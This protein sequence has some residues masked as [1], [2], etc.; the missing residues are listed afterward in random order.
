MIRNYFSL[1]V[2][3][4]ILTSCHKNRDGGGTGDAN[5]TYMGSP[6]VLS[7]GRYA[8]NIFQTGHFTCFTGGTYFQL[9]PFGTYSSSN[10][11]VYNSMSATWSRF[12]LSVKR[13]HY[14]AAALNNK[15]VVAGGITPAYMQSPLIEIFDLTTGQITTKNLSKARSY[16]AAAGT[17]SKILF[18][19]GILP[20][21]TTAL[22]AAV[23]IFNTETGQW[24]TDTLSQARAELSAGA[25]GNKI[26]F[27]GGVGI[28]GN[29][30]FYSDRADI[31][32]VQTGQ[33]TQATIS[34]ARKGMKV[35]A[36]GNKLFFYGGVGANG[37]AENVDVYD[38][39][40]NQW[41]V[42]SLP[43]NTVHNVMACTNNRQVIFAYGSNFSFTKLNIYD[44]GTG[45]TKTIP[46]PVPIRSSAMTVAGNKIVI[47]VGV[48]SD[49]ITRR[50]FTY[51]IKANSFDTTTFSLPQSKGQCTAVTVNN[52]ILVAGGVWDGYNAMNQREVINFK[53]V[54]IF[55]LR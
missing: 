7:E 26:V 45:N 9:V 36:A 38:V 22:T 6:E 37:Y 50:V 15:L 13:E 25:T 47:P 44:A 52:K 42:T 29:T 30:T 27:A 40:T 35:I 18:A 43:G 14:A 5:L 46:M 54:S 2:F 19:G 24:T 41:T 12:G 4:A 21:P 17:A 51:D 10:V 34:L 55:E 23:D 33:W 1:L 20:G 3:L 31:Y 53:T 8:I 48:M 39:Q 32:D 16:L 11:D 28:N 49:T